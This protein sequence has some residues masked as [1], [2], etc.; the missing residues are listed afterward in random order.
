[1]SQAETTLL[2]GSLGSPK[3]QSDTSAN[4]LNLQTEANTTDSNNDYRPAIASMLLGLQYRETLTTSDQLL[5]D[6]LAGDYGISFLIR[7]QTYLHPDGAELF[8]LDEIR[9]AATAPAGTVFSQIRKANTAD[10]TSY[11]M[12]TVTIGK[13]TFGRLIFGML[14]P[15]GLR[16]DQSALS[17]FHDI[18]RQFVESAEI[19]SHAA[20]HLDKSTSN[21]D[22]WILVNRSSGR[23]IAVNR[24]AAEL[25]KAP[26]LELIDCEFG[27]LRTQIG[28]VIGRGLTMTSM[29]NDTLPLC[30]IKV[31]PGPTPGKPQDVGTF[32]VGQM[33]NKISSIQT[34]AVHLRAATCWKHESGE[35]DLAHL[36]ESAATELDQQIHRFH[37]IFDFEKLETRPVEISKAI[38]ASISQL[39]QAHPSLRGVHFEWKANELV[40]STPAGAI[41]N[42]IEVAIQS[43]T[44]DFQEPA[45]VSISATAEEDNLRLKI[46]SRLENQRRSVQFNPGWSQ[47]AIHLG[48]RLQGQ[49]THLADQEQKTLT[50]DICFNTRL[51]N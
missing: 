10:M 47:L 31:E 13:P 29:G 33:R 24:T 17:R 1:M 48:A 9:A 15:A 37:L 21:I 44:H 7:G 3:F 4:R 50:T 12:M 30:L 27:S 42:L 41:E 16:R 46:S 35:A 39:R 36:I 40:L 6:D 23:T 8:P 14:V 34:A 19:A 45:L 2:Y 43:H 38:S 22:P 32:L 20:A 18:A 5:L 11:L 49:V 25:L 28:N 26:P 51:G